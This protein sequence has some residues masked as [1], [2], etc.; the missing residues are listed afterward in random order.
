MRTFSKSEAIKFGWEAAKKNI[1][2]FAVTLIIFFVIQ[3]VFS[4]ITSS[5]SG[6]SFFLLLLVNL[7]IYVVG[8]VLGLGMI[9]ISLKFVDK[10]VPTYQDLF[11]VLRETDRLVRYLGAAILY[12]LVVGLGFI[13]LIIPGIYLYLKYS[14]Y[15]YVIAD[16]PVGV[17]DSFK[18]SS[19]ITE[20]VKINLLLLG[21]L[22]G[23]INV[24]GALALL[25]GLFWT[26]PT[27]MVAMAYVYRQLSK[28]LTK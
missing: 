26:I 24:A 12:A 27:S 19:Q 8:A 11:W 2:F 21:L 15:S 5:L 13:A 14:F 28:D 10:E 3:W 7:L 25:V 4:S 6:Q 22:L 18:A 20:G 17:M 1:K 16:R 23:L 9:K